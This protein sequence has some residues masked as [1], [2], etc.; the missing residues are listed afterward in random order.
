M[1]WWKAAALFAVDAV[2]AVA[3]ESAAVRALLA[4]GVAVLICSS[5][6]VGMKL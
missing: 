4:V 6:K 1:R 3:I 5:K 2:L